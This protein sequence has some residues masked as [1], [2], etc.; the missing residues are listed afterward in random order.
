MPFL[1]PRRIVATYLFSLGVAALVNV[2]LI[3]AEPADPEKRYVLGSPFRYYRLTAGYIG[4][5]YTNTCWPI[6]SFNLC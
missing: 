6:Y 3:M 2:M 4:L 5:W 1:S